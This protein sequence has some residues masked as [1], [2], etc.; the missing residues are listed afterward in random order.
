VFIELLPV[1]TILNKTTLTEIEITKPFV[2][3]RRRRSTFKVF[4]FESKKDFWNKEP[5][6]T[7]THKHNYITLI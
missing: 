1:T 6:G 7:I 5:V 4:A 3:V 2:R